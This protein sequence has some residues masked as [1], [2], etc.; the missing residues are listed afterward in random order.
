M[1]KQWFGRASIAV[2]A[3]LMGTLGALLI[4]DDGGATP[5]GLVHVTMLGITTY[6]AVCAVLAARSAEGRPRTAWTTAAVALGCRAAGRLTWFVC[7]FVLH[8]TQ[9]PSL[10]Y[11]FYL[12][13]AVLFIVAMAAFLAEP[14][15][16][17]SL[18]TILDGTIAA[19]CSFLLAWIFVLNI[20]YDLHRDDKL[21]LALAL[22]HPTVDVAALGVA[23]AVLG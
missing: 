9:L 22:A 19:L 11:F 14:S 10:A 20:V 5:R 15:P 18:R 7:Q 16:R 17:S 4:V 21:A 6:A 2:P 12:S 3:V 1:G 8:R 13:S 23:A